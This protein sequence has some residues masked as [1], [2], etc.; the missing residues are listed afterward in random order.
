MHPHAYT[1]I[2]TQKTTAYA[3]NIHSYQ[4]KGK[5]NVNTKIRGHQEKTQCLVMVAIEDTS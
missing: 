1:H 3:I 5:L 4:S 2:Q